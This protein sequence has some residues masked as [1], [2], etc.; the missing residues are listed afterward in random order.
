MMK[1]TCIGPNCCSPSFL[2]SFKARP[3]FVTK[4]A[5]KKQMLI[6]AVI[7]VALPSQAKGVKFS[8]AMMYFEFSTT[9]A[10]RNP[11]ASRATVREHPK[12]QWR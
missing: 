6:D 11:M 2:L 1:I 10:K 7:F 9:N 3:N 8:A 4:T 12:M 5:Q